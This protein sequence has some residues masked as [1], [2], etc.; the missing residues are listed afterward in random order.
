MTDHYAE[1]E[2]LLIEAERH[3]LD[4]QDV[5]KALTHAVLANSQ[6]TRRNRWLR[7]IR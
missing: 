7:R 1:A 5:L 2:R 4:I 3:V 6:P